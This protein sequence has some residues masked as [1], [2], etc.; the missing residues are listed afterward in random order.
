MANTNAT[1]RRDHNNIA[2]GK[3]DGATI[4]S[5]PCTV[6]LA[7]ASS[8]DTVTFGYIPSNARILPSS[9]LYVDDCATSGSPTLDVGIGAVNGN[10]A[11]S[12]DPDAIGNGH[13]LATAANDIMVFNADIA[14]HALPAWDLVASETSDPGGILKVY[15]TV[16]DASTTQTGTIT[17]DLQYVID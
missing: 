13:A 5:L 17:L 7:A 10:L 14:S 4:K 8:G 12:D 9:R 1:Q 3:G 11:N 6:E 15:G 16:K 2:A